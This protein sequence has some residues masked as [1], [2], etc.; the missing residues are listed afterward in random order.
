MDNNYEDHFYTMWG[1][2]RRQ[3][4]QNF[5]KQYEGK[6]YLYLQTPETSFLGQS[7]EYYIYI[8]GL[9]LLKVDKELWTDLKNNLI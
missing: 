1:R 7:V 8:Y 9:K 4:C 3:N 6:N 5:K 2:S